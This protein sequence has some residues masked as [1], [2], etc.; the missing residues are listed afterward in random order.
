MKTTIYGLLLIALFPF[1][2]N[3][4]NGD[5][6]NENTQFRENFLGSGRGGMWIP[7]KVKDMTIEGSPY[8]F[9]SWNSM[10][11]IVNTKG[12][13]F[14]VMNLNYNIETKKI[15]SQMS[16][17]SV[18]QYD[19]SGID[20]IIAQNKK[21]SIVQDELFLELYNGSQIKLLKQFKVAIKEGVTNPLS[22]MDLT[23]R[24][25]AV[26]E[27]YKLYKDNTLSKFKLNKSSILNLFSD[28]KD[29]IMK[30]V[31]ENK[32]T[33]SEEYHVIRILNYI[34]TI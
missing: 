23:S 30:Y 13:K 18:F 2:S 24:R 15:E 16:K 12:D 11:S 1:C 21:Y 5:S 31:K 25:Y 9:K 17:D 4:Q 28:K 3:A 10:Y 34:N 14:K 26:S 19:M 32:L 33:Y 6:A 8:L 29:A 20:H 7:A 22:Q 27:E